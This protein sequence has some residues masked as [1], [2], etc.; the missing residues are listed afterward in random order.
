MRCSPID[1]IW[2][3]VFSACMCVDFVNALDHTVT[4]N[5]LQLPHGPVTMRLDCHCVCACVLAL[6]QW[7]VR[8]WRGTYLHLE[9]TI[10]CVSAGSLWSLSAQIRV[11]F[12]AKMIKTTNF[13]L[14]WLDGLDG[15]FTYYT[16]FFCSPASL[17]LLDVW[18]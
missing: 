13:L 10:A 12:F 6:A 17:T 3:D 18:R 11:S 9:Q 16:F 15:S 14:I 2:I 1:I 8:S 5:S 4:Q 7:V